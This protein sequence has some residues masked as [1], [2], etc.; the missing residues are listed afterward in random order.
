MYL[1]RFPVVLFLATQIFMVHT[2]SAQSE[3][4]IISLNSGDTVADTEW[5]NIKESSK[6]NETLRGGVNESS[7][8]RAVGR[9]DE[10]RSFYLKHPEH[11]QARAAKK[12]EIMALLDASVDRDPTTEAR[13]D[14]A[15]RAFCGDTS[16]SERERAIVAGFHSFHQADLRL[17]SQSDYLI[18][19]EKVARDLINQ[20]PTQPQGYESLLTLARDND[21]AKSLTLAK[22]LIAS[23][24]PESVKVGAGK[25]LTQLGLNGRVLSDVLPTLAEAKKPL[26]PTI[27]YGWASWSP[28]SLALAQTLGTRRTDA[29]VLIGLNLD[30]AVDR[31]AAEN[32]AA[33][34]KFPGHLI[35]DDFGTEGETARKLGVAGVPFVYFI[36]RSGVIRDV[37]GLIG[38]EKK[39]TD[40]GL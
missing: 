2:V 3:R 26:K 38:L 19:F 31:A 21:E 23:S 20:Y 10:L 30:V 37:R 29:V 7:A 1:S 13:L 34:N 36:D 28:G 6:V 39:L 40:L 12:A 35:Y 15:A 33:I 14:T 9:A 25:L 22:E 8:R 4:D 17:K 11:P 18:S 24:A 27:I 32:L 16:N 5:K